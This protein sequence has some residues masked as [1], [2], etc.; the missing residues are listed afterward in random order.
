MPLYCYQRLFTYQHYEV[1]HLTMPG[2]TGIIEAYSA[3]GAICKARKLW[4]EK[5]LIPADTKIDSLKAVLLKGGEM[6]H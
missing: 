5:G 6:W 2:I 1:T 3:R 4:K